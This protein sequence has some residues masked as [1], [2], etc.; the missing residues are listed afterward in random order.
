V[1][2][3]FRTRMQRIR[4]LQTGKRVLMLALMGKWIT[5]NSAMV[6]GCRAN[7]S[8]RTQSRGLDLRHAVGEIHPTKW[9]T[10]FRDRPCSIE[11][12]EVILVESKMARQAHQTTQGAFHTTPRPSKGSPKLSQPFTPTCA[13]VSKEETKASTTFQATFQAHRSNTSTAALELARP[14]SNKFRY[15]YR[16]NCIDRRKVATPNQEPRLG[17]SSSTKWSEGTL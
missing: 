13:T 17:F 12:Q 14:A 4:M 2:Q 15:H 11:A 6:A 16:T 7:R 5:F 9:G 1:G 10:S 3:A 8:M